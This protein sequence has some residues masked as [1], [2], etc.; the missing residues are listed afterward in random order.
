MKIQPVNSSET[1]KEQRAKW[2]K[3]FKSF[4]LLGSLNTALDGGRL[5]SYECKSRF[6][7]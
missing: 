6:S 2:C 5:N 4:I 3:V 7:L 1:E